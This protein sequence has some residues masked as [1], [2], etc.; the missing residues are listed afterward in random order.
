MRVSDVLGS[1]EI[2]NSEA[3]ILLSALIGKDRTWGLAHGEHV[4]ASHGQE[5]LAVWIKRRTKGEPVAYIIETQEF[6][7]RPFIIN[8]HTL[9]PRPATERL[10]E[11]A[12]ELL[13]KNAEPV[14]FTK[15]IDTDIIAAANVWKNLGTA[16]TIVDIGTGSGCIAVTVACERPDLHVIATDINDQ[17]I[18]TAKKNA[19]M[20]GAGANMEFR[21]G[22]DLDPV[23]DLRVPFF[24]VSNPPYIPDSYELEKNVRDFEPHTALYGGS[25]GADIVQRIV[26]QAKAHPQCCGYIIECRK[27]QE[28][29]VV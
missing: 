6:Y 10:V 27:D 29:W 19:T 9:I 4:L 18:V 17:T 15:E 12:L 20:L 26:A 21:K 2:P 23:A 13:S 22:Y 11:L 16:R 1:G 24:I 7:G 28:R 25:E 14:T 8:K 3:E 5:R